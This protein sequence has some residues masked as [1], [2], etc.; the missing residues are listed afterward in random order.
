[1]CRGDICAGCGDHQVVLDDAVEE[2]QSARHVVEAPLVPE[3]AAT[4]L[5]RD[6]HCH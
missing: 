5:A 4:P 2:L 3:A 6:G 1:M